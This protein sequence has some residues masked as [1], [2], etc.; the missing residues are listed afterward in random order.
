MSL[1]AANIGIGGIAYKGYL[2]MLA[3][4]EGIELVLCSRNPVVL[5]STQAQ[6]RIPHSTTSLD[7]LCDW[8]LAGDLCL[9][10]ADHAQSSRLLRPDRPLPGLRAIPPVPPDFSLGSAK[11]TTFA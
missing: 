11:N 10:L 3:A 7:V 9:R 4:W 2:P 1:R 5:E 8:H 6:Y